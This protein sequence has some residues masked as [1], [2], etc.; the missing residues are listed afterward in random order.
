[1]PTIHYPNPLNYS[2]ELDQAEMEML[3]TFYGPNK[4]RLDQYA[5]TTQNYTSFANLETFLNTAFSREDPAMV[6][7]YVSKFVKDGR[8]DTL[9]MAA[10]NE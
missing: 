4:A 2:S 9:A 7:L 1:M 8:V 5:R 3:I 10:L 6:N